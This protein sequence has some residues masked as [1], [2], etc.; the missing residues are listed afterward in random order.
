MAKRKIDFSGPSLE[1]LG[2]EN[3]NDEKAKNGT[4]KKGITKNG[5][6]KNIKRINTPQEPESNLDMT[7]AIAGSNNE[8]TINGNTVVAN[9]ALKKT[10]KTVYPKLIRDYLNAALGDNERVEIKLS[11]MENDLDINPKT[12]YKHLK[13]LRETEFYITKLQYCT[14]IKRR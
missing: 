7:T 10:R 13:I 4:G 12:L 8:N 1:D 2:L 14:E 6:T 9:T 5:N 11:V 3:K